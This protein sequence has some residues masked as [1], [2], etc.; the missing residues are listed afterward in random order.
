MPTEVRKYVRLHFK[1]PPLVTGIVLTRAFIIVC[2]LFQ[3]S[4]PEENKIFVLE[5]GGKSEAS[6]FASSTSEIE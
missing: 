1:K 4:E 6:R 5:L 3:Y 2:Q